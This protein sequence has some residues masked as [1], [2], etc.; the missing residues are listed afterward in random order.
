MKVKHSLI[1]VILDIGFSTV[2]MD[3]AR[4]AGA[5]GGTILHA[6][7][8]SNKIIEERTGLAM[9]PEKELILIL[10][11]DKI[12][13]EVLTAVN[14]VIGLQAKAKGIA[15]TIPV[16]EVSGKNLINEIKEEAE[17][18]EKIVEEKPSNEIKTESK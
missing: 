9:S 14:H 3:V 18:N 6:R 17:T 16:D 15:F 12:K 2:C 7:G 11:E 4:D 8:T 5:R 1:F 10:V 13:D